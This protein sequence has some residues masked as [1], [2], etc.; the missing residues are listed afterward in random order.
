MTLGLPK[1]VV[2]IV[3]ERNE[4]VADVPINASYCFFSLDC[5]ISARNRRRIL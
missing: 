3:A 2:K 1:A 4:R 5:S